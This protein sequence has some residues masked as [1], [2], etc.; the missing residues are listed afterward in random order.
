M[1]SEEKYV[2]FQ[3]SVSLQVSVTPPVVPRIPAQNGVKSVSSYARLS[4]YA[5]CSFDACR[6]HGGYALTERGRGRES[7]GSWLSTGDLLS[8][9]VARLKGSSGCHSGAKWRC[10]T[11]LVAIDR[12]N[13]PSSGGNAKTLPHIARK[14]SSQTKPDHLSFH[15]SFFPLREP[16]TLSPHPHSA[17]ANLPEISDEYSHPPTHP[18]AKSGPSPLTVLSSV[19]APRSLLSSPRPLSSLP[20]PLSKF[21][22]HAI[23]PSIKPP[24][25][26]PI[27]SATRQ[28]HKLKNELAPPLSGPPYMKL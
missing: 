25:D 26:I 9:T 20:P 11:R 23:K 5:R 21:G 6:T 24:P 27:N 19:K 8:R 1:F 13:D 7:G 18:P 28:P 4:R 16:P 3:R 22:L 2:G 14:K 10:V 15:K 17:P 12:L